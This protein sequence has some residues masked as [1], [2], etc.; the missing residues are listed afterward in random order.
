MAM[1]TYQLP[2][3]VERSSR[4]SYVVKLDKDHYAFISNENLW[5]LMQNP[6]TPFQVIMKRDPRSRTER[7]WIV[8]LKTE[9]TLGFKKPMFG[10]DGHRF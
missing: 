7:P 1:Y 10:P 6:D 3:E 5:T 2:F 4:C 8:V 9:W